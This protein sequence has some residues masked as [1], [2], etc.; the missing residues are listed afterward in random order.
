MH[1]YISECELPVEQREKKNVLRNLIIVV[2]NRARIL[3]YVYIVDIYK[4]LV[5]TILCS[6]YVRALR[7]YTF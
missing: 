7:G 6:I 3:L 2:T 1:A 5:C 4:G